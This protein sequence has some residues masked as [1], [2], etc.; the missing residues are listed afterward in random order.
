MATMTQ[1]T[2]VFYK[3]DFATTDSLYIDDR[4]AKYKNSLSSSLD[5]N[6]QLLKVL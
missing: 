6:L 3:G 5:S 1:W 2:L 4:I